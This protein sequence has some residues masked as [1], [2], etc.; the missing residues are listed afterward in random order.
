MS[1]QA[2]VSECDDIVDGPD[3]DRPLHEQS[4]VPDVQTP[5]TPPRATTASKEV[6]SGLSNEAQDAS[7]AVGS[8]R[9]FSGLLKFEALV[10][11][12]L[13]YADCPHANPVMISSDCDAERGVRLT[14]LYNHSPIKVLSLILRFGH[15]AF[16]TSI[17]S[18][19]VNF[20]QD[21]LL[22]SLVKL[23]LTEMTSGLLESSGLDTSLEILRHFP[24]KAISSLAA[25][26]L[27]RWHPMLIGEFT[28]DSEVIV[29]A[30]NRLVTE[31]RAFNAAALEGKL[32]PEPC[33]SHS[34]ASEPD[35][36]G[37]RSSPRH[38]WI[39]FAVS[40]SWAS[41]TSK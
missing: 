6:S 36:H 18:I 39:S 24:D 22:G 21:L 25:E 33:E 31:N 15:L 28:Q 40:S 5:T 37:H 23:G 32:A 27:E 34:N 38:P 8:S 11:N 9:S 19:D 35:P 30:I 4:T 3:L 7:E 12:H 2:T 20:F 13:T 14:E 26:L 10:K 41:K 29:N 17:T 1:L 16:S